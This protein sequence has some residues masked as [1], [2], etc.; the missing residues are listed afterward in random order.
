MA[1]IGGAY[2]DVDGRPRRV[3]MRPVSSSKAA[4]RGPPIASRPIHGNDS[5]N[6]SRTHIP[7]PQAIRGLHPRTEI[8]IRMAI[9]I[10]WGPRHRHHRPAGWLQR[11]RSGWHRSPSTPRGQRRVPALQ[12]ATRPTAHGKSGVRPSVTAPPYIRASNCSACAV[13]VVHAVSTA[14]VRIPAL[15]SGGRYRPVG[16]IRRYHFTRSQ[17]QGPSTRRRPG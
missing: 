16:G 5:R 13:T 4:R 7:P 2:T 8:E 6:I 1:R 15:P 14:N 10:L 11:T 3:A 12:P 17:H 9:D